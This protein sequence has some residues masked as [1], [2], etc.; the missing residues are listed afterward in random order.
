VLTAR[1]TILDQRPV[2]DDGVTDA[3]YPQ[4]AF[5]GAGDLPGRG[6]QPASHAVLGR[7][8][9][10]VQM[11]P[12]PFENPDANRGE[13]ACGSC[14]P[15]RLGYGVAVYSDADRDAMHAGSR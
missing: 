8:A 12:T 14:A 10:K 1:W 2:L 5:A 4:R 15:R 3:R 13:I 11:K 9:M 6:A 7:A